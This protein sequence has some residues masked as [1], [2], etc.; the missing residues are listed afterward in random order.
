MSTTW[1]TKLK[2]SFDLLFLFGNGIKPFEADNN[3][4]A[5]LQSLWIPVIFFP[6]GLASAWLWPP[7]DLV[8]VPKLNILLTQ[9]AETIV[10]TGLG[11]LIMWLASIALDRRDRFWIVFQASNWVGIPLSLLSAPFLF[12]ALMDW[13]PREVMDRIF[14]VILY[15]GFIVNACIF[16]RGLKINWELAGFLA[17]LGIVVGQLVQNCADWINGVPIH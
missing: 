9:T 12:L 4:K 5:G 17:C 10:D 3:K 2:G 11:I 7:A 8:N 15:Y 6:L 16:F 1:K 14:T 13:Y